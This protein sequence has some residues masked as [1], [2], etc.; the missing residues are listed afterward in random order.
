MKVLLAAALSLGVVGCGS[1]V[2]VHDVV[3][4]PDLVGEGVEYYVDRTTELVKVN[5]DGWV[6]LKSRA[7]EWANDVRE[8][9]YSRGIEEM[10]YGDRGQD[11]ATGANGSRGA[12]GATGAGGVAGTTGATGANG[13]AGTAGVAGA[14]GPQGETGAKGETGSTGPQG[15]AGEDGESFDEEELEELLEEIE[16]YFEEGLECYAEEA[17]NQNFIFITCGDLTV[18]V[19]GTIIED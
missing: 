18:R 5:D 3:N 19:K 8:Y 12:T 13:A 6:E 10:R 11:G 1:D 7:G 2:D 16:E 4:N 17:N 15:P 14:T 9:F